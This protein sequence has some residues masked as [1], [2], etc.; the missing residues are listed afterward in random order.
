MI[1]SAEQQ[2]MFDR[3]DRFYEHA[4]QPAMIEVERAACG[5]DY[6]GTSWTTR[7]EAH[8]LAGLLN[9]RPERRLLDIGAGSGWPSLYLARLTGCD[10]ALVDIPLAGLR[11]AA[12]RAMADRLAGDSWIIAADG[13]AL[14][15]ERDTFDAVSHSDLLC[16]VE[17]KLTILEECR[18]VI[19]PGGWMGFTV[20]SISPHVSPA[21]RTRAAAAGPPFKVVSTAYPAMLE[22]AGWIIG[23]CTD[24]TSEYEETARTMLRE[25]EIRCDRLIKLW[26]GAEF[27]ARMERL[28]T[29]IEAIRDGL[30]RRELFVTAAVN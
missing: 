23:E 2:A 26:G 27:I 15:F 12:E 30:L 16:C 5:C 25:Q 8:R 6:G 28:R 11:L 20:I 10:V 4:L 22:Q 14:P 1:R 19:V 18:R 9:L 21:D 29:A 17:A 24:V 7:T 3:L 13:A